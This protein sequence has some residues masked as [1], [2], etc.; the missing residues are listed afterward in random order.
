M[1]VLSQLK[2]ESPEIPTLHQPKLPADI[3]LIND[4]MLMRLLVTF[5]RWGDFLQTQLAYQE[6]TERTAGALL[7]K[8]EALYVLANK[9]E[10]EKTLTLVKI[11]MNSDPD[12]EEARDFLLIAKNKAVLIKALFDSTIRDAAVCSRELSRRTGTADVQTRTNRHGA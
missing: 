11:R 6:V 3:A 1:D 12:I 4:G 7:D 10:G 9:A 5:T 2:V 8:L